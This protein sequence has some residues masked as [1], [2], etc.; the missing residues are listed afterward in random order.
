ML[1]FCG[2]IKNALRKFKRMALRNEINV[3]NAMF[4]IM[5]VSPPTA[6]RYAKD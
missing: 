4:G 1:G 6:R 3:T 5:L 2:I